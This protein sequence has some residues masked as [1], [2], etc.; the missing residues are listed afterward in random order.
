MKAWLQSASDFLGSP[1]LILTMACS[2][3]FIDLVLTLKPLVM[4]RC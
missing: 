2:H 1:D 4:S 3:G